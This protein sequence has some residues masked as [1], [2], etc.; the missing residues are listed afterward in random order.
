MKEYC[1]I[2]KYFKVP[3]GPVP[4]GGNCTNPAFS[5]F[6]RVR[7]YYNPWVGPDGYGKETLDLCDKDGG[8]QKR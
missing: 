4:A 5:K 3:E 6:D 1:Q 7:G 2:C 8:F